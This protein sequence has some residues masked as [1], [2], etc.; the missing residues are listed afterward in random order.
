MGITPSGW[1]WLNGYQKRKHDTTK[2]V[3][4]QKCSKFFS[5]LSARKDDKILFVK[6]VIKNPIWL[7][8]PNYGCLFVP[9]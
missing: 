6:I 8:I 9:Q 1:N 3:Y 4:T 2:V 5:N 7:K